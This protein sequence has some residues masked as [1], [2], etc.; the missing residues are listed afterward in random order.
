MA[1]EEPTAKTISGQGQPLAAR[2]STP[3]AQHKHTW[4]SLF[5]FSSFLF[6]F[7]FPFLPFPFSQRQFQCRLNAG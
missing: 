7:P 2:S 1:L 5:A 3:G 4:R 6:P